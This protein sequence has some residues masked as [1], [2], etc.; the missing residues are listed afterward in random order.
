M[1]GRSLRGCPPTIGSHQWRVLLEW[2]PVAVPVVFALDLDDVDVD[3]VVAAASKNA[4]R[5]IRIW[6]HGGN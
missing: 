6:V 1:K 3:A 4:A 5:C 2:H